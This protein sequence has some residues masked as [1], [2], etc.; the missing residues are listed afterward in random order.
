MI[1]SPG[2]RRWDA[3]RVTVAYRDR[4]IRRKPGLLRGDIWI[5]LKVHPLVR[6]S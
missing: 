6:A 5:I 4:L 3:C 2:F 1:G